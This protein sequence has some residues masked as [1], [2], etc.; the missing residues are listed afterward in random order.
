MKTS[1]AFKQHFKFHT[2]RAKFYAILVA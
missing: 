1:A 2:A